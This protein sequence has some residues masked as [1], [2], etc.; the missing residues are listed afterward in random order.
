MF[1]ACVASA[2]GMGRRGDREKWK[3]GIVVERREGSTCNKSLQTPLLPTFQNRVICHWLVMSERIRF[4]GSM[5]L[6]QNKPSWNILFL[7]Y[8]LNT[9]I[10]Y[11]R[12]DHFS[13]KGR[14][15]PFNLSSYLETK[16]M[17]PYSVIKWQIIQMRTASRESQN[18]TYANV[19]QVL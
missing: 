13:V 6:G 9:S 18:R 17:W 19:V 1:L 11:I 7:K 3:R 12:T 15:I 4:H 8:C 16:Q 14:R 2:K 5:R 10:Y